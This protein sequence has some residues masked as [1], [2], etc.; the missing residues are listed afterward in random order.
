MY[1]YTLCDGHFHYNNLCKRTNFV[2]LVMT[3]DDD[4]MGELDCEI[5][6]DAF[7]DLCYDTVFA[8]I[9]IILLRFELMKL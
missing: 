8:Y 3:F 4:L 5:V 6:R 2:L 1:V 7:C 9:R